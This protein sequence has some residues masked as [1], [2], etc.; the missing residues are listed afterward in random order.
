MTFTI[1]PDAG[2]DIQDVLVDGVGMG[3]IPEYT[4]HNVRANHIIEAAFARHDDSC[5]GKRFDDVDTGK[6]YHEGID[7][8]R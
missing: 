7:F 6:W 3:G 5:P 8:V 4:F 1:A 2:Y